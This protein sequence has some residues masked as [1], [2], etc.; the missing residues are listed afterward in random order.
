MRNS[1][2]HAYDMNDWKV[3]NIE[4]TLWLAP[5]KKD[6]NTKVARFMYISDVRQFFALFD[7]F[8]LVVCVCVCVDA[9]VWARKSVFLHI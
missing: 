8:L 7:P 2:L 1:T 9:F 5:E 4:W 3:W 6:N